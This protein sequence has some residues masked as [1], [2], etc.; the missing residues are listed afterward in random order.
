M[1][2]HHFEPENAVRSE[3]IESAKRKKR[4]TF[5]LAHHVGEADVFLIAGEPVTKKDF[6][7]R[8]E[9]EHLLPGASTVAC[10]KCQRTASPS[11]WHSRCSF[12]QP[13]GGTCGGVFF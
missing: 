7:L 12:A 6:I 9:M 4:T 13:A 5:F 11:A 2:A 10:S 1:E 8:S 3:M